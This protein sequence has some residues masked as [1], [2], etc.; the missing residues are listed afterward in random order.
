MP[1]RKLILFRPRMWRQSLSKR[2]LA[3]YLHLPTGWSF[4]RIRELTVALS[5]PLAQI[6]T[7]I[8]RARDKGHFPIV[9][10]PVAQQCVKLSST[11]FWNTVSARRSLEICPHC[12]NSIRPIASGKTTGFGW[13]FPV[14]LSTRFYSLWIA[15]ITDDCFSKMISRADRAIPTL[16]YASGIRSVFKPGSRIWV[17]FVPNSSAN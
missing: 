15:F 14:H 6:F 11:R 12:R 13:K 1:D 17:C 10:L 3:P 9:V 8:H 16:S 2:Q 4:D 5:V 7:N